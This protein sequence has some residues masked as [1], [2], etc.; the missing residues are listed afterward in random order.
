M[1]EEFIF[2]TED[3]LSLILLSK[4]L[5]V[6]NKYML[7]KKELKFYDPE[8]NMEFLN[9]LFDVLGILNYMLIN[10]YYVSKKFINYN[11]QYVELL[12]IMYSYDYKR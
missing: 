1:V 5:K 11:K 9:R 10:K 2:K 12:K 4:N 3:N 8:E 6:F 7:N